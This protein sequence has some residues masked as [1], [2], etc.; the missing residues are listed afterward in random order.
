MP[1]TGL[2]AVVL[3]L[4]VNAV[5]GTYLAV[6][7]SAEASP[8]ASKLLYPSRGP[9]RAVRGAERDVPGRSA[10]STHRDD[11]YAW[12]ASRLASGRLRH[13]SVGLPAVT[14]LG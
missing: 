4:V 6:W 12:I 14:N 3:N 1:S 2:S 10:V 5:D 7:P 11:D 13:A 9:F 8:P